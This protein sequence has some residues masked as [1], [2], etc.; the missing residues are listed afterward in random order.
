MTRGKRKHDTER[1]LLSSPQK[2]N[3]LDFFKGVQTTLLR[4]VQV[5]I[6]ANLKHIF[7]KNLNSTRSVNMIPKTTSLEKQ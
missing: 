6:A 3:M 2:S 1:K 5:I 7:V 4:V